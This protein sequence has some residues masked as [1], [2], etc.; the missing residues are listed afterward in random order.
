MCTTLTEWGM[1][2][3]Y[4]TGPFKVPTLRGWMVYLNPDHL[5]EVTK[6]P[7]DVMSFQLVLNDVRRQ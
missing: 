7:S 5:E 3:Q 6:L 4:K 1:S 2:C